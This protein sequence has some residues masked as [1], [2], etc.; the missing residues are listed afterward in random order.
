MS[1]IFL[2]LKFYRPDCKQVNHGHLSYVAGLSFPLSASFASL[3]HS[4]PSSLLSPDAPNSFTLAASMVTCIDPH[5]LWHPS[6][7]PTLQSCRTDFPSCLHGRAVMLPIPTGTIAV[8]GA[9]ALR[10]KTSNDS[11]WH[12]P[13]QKLWSSVDPNRTP[14][15]KY[16][17]FYFILQW[18]K[19]S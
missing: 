5:L 14:R 12:H 13:K 7:F 17:Y 2:I 11:L 18:R 16:P 15:F 6:L 1:N 4:S 3:L 19:R 9:T 10:H 8:L